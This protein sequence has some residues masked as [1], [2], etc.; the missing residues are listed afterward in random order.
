MS[1]CQVIKGQKNVY[2]WYKLNHIETSIKL[3][4][5]MCGKTIPQI[6]TVAVSLLFYSFLYFQIFS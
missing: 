5:K 6:S 4:V 3:Y 2:I 1:Q